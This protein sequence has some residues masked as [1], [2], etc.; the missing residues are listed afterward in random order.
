VIYIDR[1]LVTCPTI[2]E[3][4]AARKARATAAAF[5]KVKA[6]DRA[7]RKHSFDPKVFAHPDVVQALTKLFHGKCVFCETTLDGDELA[8]VH[9]RPAGGALDLKG[10]FAPDH[11]WGL[12]YTWANLYSSCRECERHKGHR[13]PVRGTRASANPLEGRQLA[14]ENP[15]LLD[16]CA[17]VPS[18]H[19]V[20][21]ETGEERGVVTS[22]TARGRQTIEVLGLNRRSLV[23]KRR[24]MGDAVEQKLRELG[25]ASRNFSKQPARLKPG[26]A[27]FWAG[28][29]VILAH[30]LAPGEPFL[31][32]RRQIV[33]TW[34]RQRNRLE[35]G[36]IRETLLRAGV[37]V[38]APTPSEKAESFEAFDQ[39]RRRQKDYS[40]AGQ[41]SKAGYFSGA[42]LIERIQLDNFRVFE[43]L[44]VE[45]NAPE[46]GS[47]PWLVFLGENGTGKSS[48]LQAIALTLMG[49]KDRRG[50]TYNARS[51]VR[52]VIK[53]GRRRR[54]ATK[55]SVRVW[56]TGFPE[57]ITLT[58]S[59]RLN[60]FRSNE[61][62]QKVLL[63]G[64]G[65]T[66]LL[67]RRGTT[68][69]SKTGSGRYARVRNL[70]NPFV[71]LAD[72][73]GWLMSLSRK[74]FN[75]A[76]TVIKALLGLDK[77]K[78]R[79]RRLR[80]QVEIE[81]PGS[82]VP[83]SQLSDGYQSTLA[84]GADIMRVMFAEWTDMTVAE[85]VVLI[86]ELESHLHPTWKM[87]I[88]TDLRACFPRVQFLVTTHDPLCLRGL[89]K[90]EVM[91]MKRDAHERVYAVSDLPDVRGLH[92]DQLLTSDHFG[93]NTTLDP[94]TEAA[95]D[96]YYD[97][98]VKP[99]RS[100]N[101]NSL[102][103]QYKEDLRLTG[104]LGSDRREQMMLE[105][106]DRFLAAAE[107]EPDPERRAQ[108]REARTR[109]LVSVM[110]RPAE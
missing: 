6:S 27:E 106:I 78:A 13:F 105:G 40:L 96:R 43:N 83:L 37:A 44:V 108:M 21:R 19:L 39:F 38:R 52:N 89:N 35:M 65:A 101:D 76:A 34:F 54:G 17:D 56:I 84:L 90:G 20:F 51:A 77:D 107:R 45:I 81:V 14:R 75:A 15:L 26:W 91:V 42:R 73:N 99:S 63:L 97:L 104:W 49:D 1:N 60:A 80:G 30:L 50:L 47:A 69:E 93:L 5:Y 4:K 53:G 29:R 72:A 31:A 110:N 2:L 36:L 10:G 23:L 71:P 41:Q 48:I 55:G 62:E 66:R 74:H 28:G 95:F 24:V 64:Y 100:R 46:T 16:P 102:L 59:R 9:Y 11:Y 85:G 70:F 67:P 22:S 3:S 8:V 25:N 98:L 33:H 18:D 88:V 61:T 7:Q 92:I 94:A 79:I 87:R 12:A 103:K 68:P 32:F 109:R 57:P 58:F 82:R 86:D